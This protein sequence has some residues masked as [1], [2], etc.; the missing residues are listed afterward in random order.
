MSVIKFCGIML[1]ALTLIRIPSCCK[2]CSSVLLIY[3]TFGCQCLC[4]M[5]G[6]SCRIPLRSLAL[7]PFRTKRLALP[8]VPLSEERLPRANWR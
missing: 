3:L 7:G 1:K 8:L 5:P 4:V 2:T 6:F